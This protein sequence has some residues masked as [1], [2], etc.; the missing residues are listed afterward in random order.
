MSILKDRAFRNI[1]LISLVFHV[2]A[3]VFSDGFYHYDEHFREIETANYKMG[4]TPESELGWEHD[5]RV[6]P[7]LQPGLFFILV[8]SAHAVGIESPF[9][10]TFLWRLMAALLAFGAAF[11]LSLC[12]FKWF[13]NRKDQLY[14]VGLL[15]LAWFVPYLHV[16]PS[17]ESFASSVFIL[18]ISAFTLCEKRSRDGRAQISLAAAALVGALMG[19]TFEF[20]FHLVFMIAG[21]VAW[22]L[23]VARMKAA[24]LVTMIA[25]ATVVVAIGS[26]IDFWGYGEWTLTVW[27]YFKTLFMKGALAND[28]VEPW[29]FYFQYLVVILPPLSLLL[30]VSSIVG[31]WKQRWHVVTWTVVPFALFHTVV[32]HKE[33]RY[34]FPIYVY[35]PLMAVY[36]TSAVAFFRKTLEYRKWMIFLLVVNFATL[37]HLSTTTCK[38]QMGVYEFVYSL[39]PQP[40]QYF[41][42]GDD[43]FRPSGLQPRFYTRKVERLAVVTSEQEVLAALGSRPQFWFV[44]ENQIQAND[45]QS[46]CQMQWSNSPAKTFGAWSE[47]WLRRFK[48]RSWFLYQCQ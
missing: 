45:L 38:R 48:V 33:P 6:R 7:W 9:V 19:L 18:G 4:L 22:L 24:S 44:T 41:M 27:N 42:L 21:F 46:R 43:P 30:A 2:V 16:R 26:V 12:C 25:A 8:R 36:A 40:F 17:S 3:C 28:G 1:L 14:A 5:L 10:I 35:S 39:E 34:L 20:R 47:D 11:A 15:N 29:W 31:M 37:V 13:Q 23:F 32:G